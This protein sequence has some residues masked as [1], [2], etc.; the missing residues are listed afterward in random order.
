MQDTILTVASILRMSSKLKMKSNAMTVKKK[1]ITV[2]CFKHCV[3]R[4]RQNKKQKKKLKNS[5]ENKIRKK[6]VSKLSRIC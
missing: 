4:K 3:H 1:L 6:M 5:K 2:L